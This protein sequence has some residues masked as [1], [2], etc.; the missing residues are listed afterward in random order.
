MMKKISI[1]PEREYLRETVVK[2]QSNHYAIPAFQRDFVWKPNQIIDLF[3]SISKGYPIGS[4]LLWKPLPQD[5]YPIKDIYDKIHTEKP[6][7]D[8]QYYILDGRQ[9]LTAFYCSVTDYKDKPA[10]FKVYYNLEKEVFEI[11]G[12]KKYD[13]RNSVLLSDVFDTFEMLGILQKVMVMHDVEKRNDYITKIKMLNTILQSYEIGEMILENCTLDEA[14]TVFSR[15]NSMATDISKVEMLQALAYKNKKSVLV[16]EEI[17]ALI[18]DLGDYDFD[19]IKADD[20]LIC[21]YRYLGKFNFDNNIK[22]LQECSDLTSIVEKL[23]VDLRNAVEFL[24]DDCGVL[25]YKHLPY[26]RQLLAICAFFAIKKKYSK[27]DLQELKKWFFYTT[28]QQSFQNGSLGNVRPIFTRFDEFLKGEKSTA[29]DY[30][31]V[32][33][34]TD[35]EFTYSN[36]SALSNLIAMCQVLRAKEL[37]NKEIR[38]YGD[39]K[40][41]KKKPAYTFVM[42]YPDD[43][44]KLN[45]LKKKNGGNQVKLEHLILTDEMVN[46]LIRKQYTRFAALRKKAFADMV[47]ER[48]E[49]LGIKV[50]T[51]SLQAENLDVDMLMDEF[52]DFSY[53]E[54][55][56]F[57]RAL[58]VLDT[59]SSIFPITSIGENRYELHSDLLMR[60]YRFTKEDARAFLYNV[61]TK[62]C[63]GEDPDLYFEWLAALER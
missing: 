7:I 21:C 34:D 15:I 57:C 12:K 47:T 50:S 24:H 31:E 22:Q 51:K 62:Y 59:G 37:S 19:D 33:L 6:E 53:S 9:R 13:D 5:T 16:A 48:L 46:C 4:I 52:D 29:I 35:F 28:A 11:P 27:D 20:V 8:A 10:K 2:M 54:K 58:L 17:K 61:S 40:F 30:E 25:S 26:S 43:K 32:E 1:K 60:K 44:Q 3:D 63:N 41:L 42:L 18:E 14:S 36:S 39:F 55:A 56:N 49:K 23:K 45:K 38:Y